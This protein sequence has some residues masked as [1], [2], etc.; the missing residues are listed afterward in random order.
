MAEVLMFK[1]VAISL[2]FLIAPAV[3]GFNNR[4]AV[5]SIGLDSNPCT[6]ASPC[7]SF[8]AAIAQ[9]NPGGEIVALDS[10]GYGPFTI[11]ASLTISGAPGVHAAVTATVGTAITVAVAPSDR[12]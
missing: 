2:T 9:T 12:V 1:R 10:A 8:G 4:S 11:D 3:F 7:R 6:V 5:S